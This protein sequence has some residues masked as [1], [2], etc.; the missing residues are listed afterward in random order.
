MREN[1][2]HYFSA[3]DPVPEWVQRCK[4]VGAVEMVFGVDV[5]AE[6]WPD[7]HSEIYPRSAVS[8]FTLIH[9]ISGKAVAENFCVGMVTFLVNVDIPITL[10]GAPTTFHFK[11]KGVGEKGESG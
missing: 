3:G 8:D 9:V 6:R 1:I 4:P 11:P 7:G 5:V 10:S 2:T